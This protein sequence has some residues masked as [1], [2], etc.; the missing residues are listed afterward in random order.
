MNTFGT[1]Y[2]LTSFGESHSPAMGGVIDGMPAGVVF[3]LHKVDA[4]LARRRPG[5]SVLTSARSESD[6]VRFLSGLMACDV[7]GGSMQPLKEDSDYG[8]SLGTPVGFVIE[9][10]DAHSADYDALKHVYRPSHADFTWDARYGIRDWRGGGRASGR[11][12]VSRVVAG[13]FAM[14]LL[15]LHGIAISSCIQSL[16]GI[17]EPSCE[18][19]E[20]VIA[21]ARA[22]ADSVGGIV[23]CRVSG[24][25]AGIGNPVFGKLQQM[26]A[27]AMLS[28]GGVKGFEYGIGFRFAHVRGSEVADEFVPSSG[29]GIATATNFSGGI[30]GGISNGMEIRFHVAVKPTPTISRTFRTVDDRGHATTVKAYG[31]HDPSIVLRVCPV[32]EA[33]AA[34]VLVDAMLMRGDAKWH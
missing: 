4:Q 13:A 21:E 7:D 34:M 1:L 5:G 26:L 9:N 18:E 12:T 15:A 30:Q 11:E 17:D 27:S 29:G 28:I 8:I 31:R 16:G 10:R 3:D 14:Q 23:E 33:M 32:V 2:R 24:M 22:E 19:I 25:P 6:S 20:R